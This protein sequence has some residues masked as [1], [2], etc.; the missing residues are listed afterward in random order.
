MTTKTK[1]NNHIPATVVGASSDG[2]EN[3]SLV[4]ITEAGLPAVMGMFEEDAGIGIETADKDSFAIP[5]S[6]LLQGLSPN[7]WNPRIT[8][9][10]QGTSK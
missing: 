2:T 7:G 6:T 1:E 3:T 9:L 4:S 5:F 10:G 8:H